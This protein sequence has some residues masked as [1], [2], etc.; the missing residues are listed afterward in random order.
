MGYVRLRPRKWA[1]KQD[2]Q[3]RESF[4][5]DIAVLKQTPKTDLWFCDETGVQGDPEPREILALRGS[6]IRLPHTGSHIRSSVIGSVRPQDGK[7]VC[8]LLPYVDT[9]I[10]QIYVDELNRRVRRRHENI[11]V[12]DNASWHKT[13]SLR[14]GILRPCYLPTYSPDLNVIE[15]LWLVVKR[16]FFSWFYTRNHDV[17]DDRITEAL[18]FY[19]ERPALIRSICNM[20]TF[21]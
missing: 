4:R 1:E 3:V 6:R 21:G 5:K 2:Q 11:V 14:W 10:F 16:D 13:R 7:F 18:N 12:L 9:E 19:I 8:L 20:N 17:L 15:R